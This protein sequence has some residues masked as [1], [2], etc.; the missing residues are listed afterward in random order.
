[1]TTYD[2]DYLD[3]KTFAEANAGAEVCGRAEFNFGDTEVTRG[4]V[5]GWI[6][7]GP[8]GA[9]VLVRYA[10]GVAH[11]LA[12]CSGNAWTARQYSLHGVVSWTPPS[13]LAHGL[14]HHCRAQDL[15]LLGKS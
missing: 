3:P 10:P 14:Y 1:M 7:A 2:P 11:E 12:T 5:A 8:F 9:W 15:V 4:T 13:W 6:D